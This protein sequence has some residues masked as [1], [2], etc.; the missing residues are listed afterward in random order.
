MSSILPDWSKLSRFRSILMLLWRYG[1]ETES[2]DLPTPLLQEEWTESHELDQDPDVFAA[3]LEAMGATFIKLGQMLSTRAD[4]LPPLHREALARLQDNVKALDYETLRERVEEEIGRPISEAFK[5]FD[6]KP[7]A[8]ASIAQVHAATLHDGRPV[9]VKIQRPGLRS[10]VH[11]DLD[12]LQQ[13]ADWMESWTDA[14]RRIAAGTLLTTFRNAILRELDFTSEAE[15]LLQLAGQLKDTQRL[16]VPS[17]VL[18]LTTSRVLVMDRLKGCPI[19]QVKTAPPNGDVLARSLLTHYLHAILDEGFFHADPHPGNLLLSPDGKEIG[20]ID[21]G[22]VGLLTERTRKQLLFLLLAI[23]SGDETEIVRQF[24]RLGDG[25]N[26]AG[27]DGDRRGLERDIAPILRRY[28]TG[29]AT[30]NLGILLFELVQ[31]GAA[32]GFRPP[33]ELSLVGKVLLHLDESA[34]RLAPNFNP[35]EAIA[36]L[37]PHHIAKSV[38][39]SLRFDQILFQGLEGSRL[40]MDLPGQAHQILSDLSEGNL[41]MRLNVLDEAAWLDSFKKIANRIAA[42]TIIAGLLVGAA[43]LSRVP[44]TFT[45]FGYPLLALPLFLVAA[46]AGFALL[47]DILVLDRRNR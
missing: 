31:R 33:P 28:R 43:I 12:I 22:M 36:D 15:H 19:H 32:R 17:P 13:I 41:S 46:V 34:R 1:G 40:A 3:D 16:R 23:D 18:E 47:F 37:L 27:K 26:G 20:I 29:A 9:V 30:D 44:D 25:G 38:K 21:L 39:D 24:L 8:A 35:A 42:G 2:T 6:I 5:S 11:D 45:I 14:G 10:Q 7:L 4:L